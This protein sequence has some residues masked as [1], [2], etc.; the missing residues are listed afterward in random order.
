MKNKYRIFIVWALA[1][2]LVTPS[3]A[4]A[5]LCP[6]N[7]LVVE[8]IGDYVYG[9]VPA[10][11]AQVHGVM[12]MPH[13]GY[14]YSLIFKPDLNEGRLHGVM[15]LHDKMNGQAS[16]QVITPMEISQSFKVPFDAI[17]VRIEIVKRFNWG[18]DDY[19]GKLKKGGYSV[20]LAPANNIKE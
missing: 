8:F 18:P 5:Q 4:S 12:E 7:N 19:G 10:R 3:I 2:M 13:P 14:M 6:S 20:C 9:E 16:A 15:N 17:E 11:P 1:F